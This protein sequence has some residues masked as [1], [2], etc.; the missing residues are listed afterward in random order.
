MKASLPNAEP[1]RRHAL[2]AYDFNP[3]LA[4]AAVISQD[5]DLI[6]AR[7]LTIRT[8]YFLYD[9]E[10]MVNAYVIFGLIVVVL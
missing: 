9:P 2:R 3:A 10:T 6:L 4:R 8:G 5:R 1:G 7:S